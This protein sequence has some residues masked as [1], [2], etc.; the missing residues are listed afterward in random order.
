MDQQLD[1]LLAQ[2]R[3]EKVI[4][5]GPYRDDGIS[6]SRYAKGKTRA[7]WQQTVNAILAGEVDELWVWELSRASRDREAT[8][9][10]MQ[11]CV[12]NNVV[13]NVGG[14]MHDPNDPDDGF[15]LDLLAA[16]AVRESAA[17]AKRI[18]RDV[19]ARAAAGTPHGKV[20]FG[21]AR[22]YH[23]VTRVLLAQVP[24]PDTAPILREL[25]RR[26]LAGEAMYAI[27]ADL[28]ARGVP[29]PETVRRIR[30]HGEDAVRSPWRGDEIR[31]Q[32]LSPTAAGLRVHKGEILGPASWAPIIS[33]I[34]R[35]RLLAVLRPPGRRQWFGPVRHMLTGI[36]AC[37]V[38]TTP[39]RAVK[40]RNTPSYCCP[41]A[42]KR[43]ASCVCRAMR[44]LDAYVAGLAIRRLADP[45]FLEAISVREDGAQ[46]RAGELRDELGV[47]RV[48]LARREAEAMDCDDDVVV[49]SFGRVV[50]G[51]AGRIRGLERELAGLVSVPAAVIAAAGPDAAATWRNH[52]DDVVWQRQMVRAL[53]R[54]VVHPVGRRGVR[55]FDP[56]TV[57]VTPL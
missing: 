1:I 40:N 12:A 44:P 48:R 54:V 20:P 10:L 14:K 45:L 21:F 39:L 38:C 27:A 29:S 6:A 5:V 34:E 49:A 24:D 4:V 3:R 50:A 47:L 37:G 9:N 18:Q 15:M 55:G 8:A 35:A 23:P 16:L 57:E 41:G 11:A 56:S 2:A 53:L 13:L 26:V 22:Q 7:G 32:L 17:T 31:D 51:L 43:G 30:V 33:E 42:D 46:V 28:N 19:D 52:A 36:A 25:V